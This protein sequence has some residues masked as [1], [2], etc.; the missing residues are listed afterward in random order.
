MVCKVNHMTAHTRAHKLAQTLA[1]SR[2]QCKTT[3]THTHTH[4]RNCIYDD[5]GAKQASLSHTHEYQH[6]SGV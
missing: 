2:D 1:K 5:L 3:H 6:Y 4:T